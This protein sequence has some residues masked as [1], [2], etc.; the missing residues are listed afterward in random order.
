MCPLDWG[1]VRILSLQ[2]SNPTCPVQ[3]ERKLY[4][5]IYGTECSTP[6]VQR[7]VREKLEG[8]AGCLADWF[9]AY[10][11]KPA[12]DYSVYSVFDASPTFQVGRLEP[13]KQGE[14]RVSM[15]GSRLPKS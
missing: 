6:A 5:L 2:T 3:E 9:E 13:V 8:V 12:G 15:L 14:H 10:Y 11:G 7:L 4:D 1:R